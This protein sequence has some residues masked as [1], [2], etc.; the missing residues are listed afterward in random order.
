MRDTGA[1]QALRELA[2]AHRVGTDYTDW[3]GREV[4]ASAETLSAVL[5]AL[6]VPAATDAEVESS[7]RDAREEPWRRTLPPTV[8]GR[9]GRAT[10][11][12]VHVPH[13]S[14]VELTIQLEDGAVLEVRQ[15][16]H[17]VD[18][19]DVDGRLIGE[20]TFELDPVLPLGWH[21]LVAT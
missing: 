21:R 2:Q 10:R 3:Q 1:T 5:L 11:V 8:V 16:D 13:E 18:P 14:P 6:G 9:V 12:P 17:W 4:H 19:R 20:A 7:L 15:I